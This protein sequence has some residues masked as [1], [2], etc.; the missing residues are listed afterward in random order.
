VR[1]GE[2]KQNIERPV[3][4]RTATSLHPALAETLRADR[5][6]L[7]Q[8]FALR[9]RAGARIDETAF[10]DHLRT[11]VNELAAAVARVQPERVRP[12]VN[13]LFDVSLELFAASLLGPQTKHQHVIAAWHSV[14]PAAARLLAREPARV[15]GCLSNAVD[16]LTAY[17]S[18]RPEEWIEGMR[19][20]SPHCDS[21][22]QWLDVGKVLAWR[23]GLVQY[24]SAQLE[25]MR[26]LPWRLAARCFDVQEDVTEAD[27]RSRLNRME[28]DPWYSPVLDQAE[29]AK[30]S[31]RLV[32]STGGFRGFGGPCSRPPTVAAHDG[33]LFVAD[34]SETWQLLADVFGTLWHRVPRAAAARRASDPGA[35]V[36]IDLRGNVTWD[37]TYPFSELADASSYACDGQTLAVTLPTSYQVFLVAWAM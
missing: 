5:E 6:S 11:M 22:S 24:R 8:R 35:Q 30:R 33:G 10:H 18:A 36:T 12:A 27:W 32:R 34:G 21:V 7:N 26:G 13:A 23:A 2:A 31:V 4:E 1:V 9:Q 14:L 28:A 25:N 16:H 37:G 3:A 17:A 19:K 15:A 20:L 29:S